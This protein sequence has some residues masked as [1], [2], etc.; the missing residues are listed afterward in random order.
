MY[1]VQLLRS[2]FIDSE[3]SWIWINLVYPTVFHKNQVSKVILPVCMSPPAMHT[4]ICTNKVTLYSGTS[5]ASKKKDSFSPEKWEHKFLSLNKKWQNLIILCIWMPFFC[6]V[7]KLHSKNIV[8]QCTELKYSDSRPN[9]I[10]LKNVCISIWY[11]L[12]IS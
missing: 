4:G 9:R 8:Q 7:M 1:R 11:W 12:R 5:P 3:S 10:F 2:C 6:S